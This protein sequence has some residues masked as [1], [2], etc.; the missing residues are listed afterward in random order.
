LF[1]R[2]SRRWAGLVFVA[3][4]GAGA[5]FAREAGNLLVVDAP[6]P[7]DIIV[8]LAGETDYR[9]TKALALL[10]QGYGQRLLIDVPATARIYAFSQVDLAKRY[11]QDLPEAAAI[12]ICPIVGLS[13]RDESHDVA[14]CLAHESGS[15]VLLVSSDFHTRR[16]LS[17]FRHE[18]P[19]K[20]FTIAAAHNDS[21]FGTRWWT[22]REWAKTCFYEWIRFFWWSALERWK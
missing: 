4:L 21:E 22:H 2:K 17:I 5:V 15:R 19:G 20:S 3:A 1:T 14:Q 12:A 13:T 9:P 10:D 6:Q 18:I 11:A 16:A 8:V 7:S